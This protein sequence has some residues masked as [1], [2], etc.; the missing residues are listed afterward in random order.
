VI[1]K[2]KPTLMEK[3]TTNDPRGAR[4]RKAPGENPSTALKRETIY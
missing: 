1:R 4:K 3:P 2:E